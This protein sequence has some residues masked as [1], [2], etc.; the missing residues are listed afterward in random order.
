MNKEIIENL[1]KNKYLQE[2]L[3]EIE[4]LIEKNDYKEAYYKS[5]TM[6]EYINIE[7]IKTKF[8]IDM[9]NSSVINI[10]NTYLGRDEILSKDMSIVNSEYND[11]DINNV[12]LMDIE[13]LIGIIDAMYQHMVETVGEFIK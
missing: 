1:E 3:S 11:V 7:Y 2:R 12:E 5:A 9:K 8:N 4:N 10:L 6:L 13:Y